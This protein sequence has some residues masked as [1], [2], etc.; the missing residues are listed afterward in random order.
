MIPT[1]PAVLA[2]LITCSSAGAG[3]FQAC[4]T[5]PHVVPDPGMI[6]IPIAGGTIDGTIT[7]IWLDVDITTE[8][9]GDLTIELVHDGVPMTVLAPI[10]FQSLS[11]GCGG[12]DINATFTDASAITPESL[13][14]NTTEPMIFGNIAPADALSV[15]IGADASLGW[16]IRVTDSFAFDQATV[17][18][19]CLNIEYTP[20]PACDGDA[21][22]D[23]IV[24]VNDISYVLF[25]LGSPP[26]DG[27][28]N[29]DNS[30]DVN[31]ISYVLFRLGSC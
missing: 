4:T 26:P 29:G 15:F 31:D 23:N 8:W 22:G 14:D 6:E 3:N 11:F 12:D 10:G 25:R 16:T 27:D 7:E 2:A 18:Q 1:T 17:N 5:Q 19:I 9:T 13:C 20:A 24:D 28:V 21:N 30:V